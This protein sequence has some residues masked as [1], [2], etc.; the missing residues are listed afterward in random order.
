MHGGEKGGKVTQLSAAAFLRRHLLILGAGLETTHP[1]RTAGDQETS[2]AI[3]IIKDGETQLESG[4]VLSIQS[5]TPTWL[6]I[7]S[8]ASRTGKKKENY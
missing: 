6:Y 5:P 1:R 7:N 3:V 2:R 4:G 8:E